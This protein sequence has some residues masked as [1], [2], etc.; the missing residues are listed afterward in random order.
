MEENEKKIPAANEEIQDHF[1][2][3][4]DKEAEKFLENLLFSIAGAKVR[5]SLYPEEHPL[6]QKVLAELH[7]QIVKALGERTELELEFQPGRIVVDK[8]FT[9]GDREN[10]AR[11]SFDMYQRKVSRLHFDNSLDFSSLFNFL[12]FITTDVDVLHRQMEEQDNFFP[13]FHGIILDEIDYERLK[14]ARGDTEIKEE[15]TEEDISIL[16]I[17]YG[18]N[19]YGGDLEEFPI[20]RYIPFSENFISSLQDFPTANTRPLELNADQPPERQALEIFKNV[21]DMV[22]STN[23][24][25]SEILKIELA[26]QL[27]NMSREM[28]SEL[29]VQE[30][31]E[32]GK[33]GNLFS[34]FS[35]LGE[36]LTEEILAP[37]RKKARI[38]DFSQLATQVEKISDAIREQLLEK[39]EKQKAREINTEKIVGPAFLKKI[40]DSLNPADLK[41]HYDFALKKVFMNSE[42]AAAVE[43]SITFLISE[44][45]ENINS[46]DLKK[47][48]N[49]VKEALCNLNNKTFSIASIT[50]SLTKIIE[51]RV[52]DTVSPILLKALD[53]EDKDIINWGS[54]FL[55]LFNIKIEQIFL[56]ALPMEPDRIVRKRIINFVTSSRNIPVNTLKKMLAHNEWYVIRNAVTLIRKLQDEELVHLLHMPLLHPKEQ[57]RKETIH[58]LGT[59]QCK[60]ALNLLFHVYNDTDQPQEIRSL[61]LEYMGNHKDPKT[62]EIFFSLLNDSRHPTIDTRLRISGIKQLGNFKDSKTIKA[63]L[64]FIKKPHLFYRDIWDD[65]KI[66]AYNAL[67]KIGTLEARGAMISAEKYLLRK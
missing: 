62:Y 26:E 45:N 44:L 6:V 33:E 55:K 29:L 65:M 67:R 61:A 20:T 5:V 52:V 50:H 35:Y 3:H 14:T 11:F 12:R 57:V 19:G 30:L 1:P 15:T 24:K 10:I 25:E 60:D 27:Y 48:V 54:D 16:N 66:S 22:Y 23:T 36:D 53:D 42:D 17:I 28:Q 51:Q 59:I 9:V 58:A 49:C 64:K 32:N 43:K 13:E 39:K 41:D 7:K 37:M 2:E 56:E 8:V 31:L 21:V 46:G 40:F 63:L 34:L 4:S 38:G 47:A 18:K